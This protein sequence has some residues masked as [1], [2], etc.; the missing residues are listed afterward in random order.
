MPSTISCRRW[1]C[2]FWL[3]LLLVVAAAAQAQLGAHPHA[4]FGH[5]HRLGDVVGC[6]GVEAGHD[7]VGL[8]AG[9]DEDDGDVGGVGR[10]LEAAADFQPVEVG[11]DHV[12]QDQVWLHAHGDVECAL[13]GA[14]HERLVSLLPHHVLQQPEAVGGIVDDQNGGLARWC[15]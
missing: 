8:A 14:G 15:R 11:Q 1:A 10:A 3:S 6:A 7:V 9:A 12:E 13:A 2:C 5:A 4:D